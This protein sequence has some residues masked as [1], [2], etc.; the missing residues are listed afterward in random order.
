MK[1]LEQ[2]YQKFTLEHCIQQLTGTTDCINAYVECCQPYLGQ[3]KIALCYENQQ[4]ELQQWS[5]EQLDQASGY[6]ATYL[7]SLGLKAGDR[8]ATMLAKGAELLISMLAIWRIGA[9]YL[10]LFTEFET[11]AIEHRLETADT[12][13]I[14]IDEMYRERINRI[15]ISNI[16]T[17]HQQFNPK[18]IDA[19]FWTKIHQQN[20]LAPAVSRHLDDDFLMMFTS[21][22]V[23]LVKSLRVPLKALLSFKHYLVTAVDLKKEDRFF[24]MIDPAWAYGLYYGVIGALSLGHAVLWDREPFSV[25]RM[26]YLQHQHQI[27]NL[28]T[29]PTLL[30]QLYAQKTKLDLSKFSALAKVSSVGEPLNTDITYWLEQNL[31]IQTYDHYGQTETGIVLANHHGLDHLK[32]VGSVGYAVPG[33]RIVVLNHK[34]Q[35]VDQG[36][37]GML[38]IDTAHSPL[39]WFKSYGGNNRRCFQGQ[40]YLTGDM[41]RMNEISSI[42]FIARADDVILSSGYRVGPFDVESTLLECTEVQETAVIGKPDPERYE[43]IKAFIVLKQH[44][45]PSD[46][47]KERLQ[48]YVRTRLSK[49]I[50]LSEIEFVYS[51]PKTVT[52]KIQR[53]ILKQ[54]EMRRVQQAF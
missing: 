8:I 53:H 19:D 41:V 54:Q 44:L 42:E 28:M 39:F 40:Y 37:I 26:S 10:P 31:N 18:S 12:Q 51:L 13:L 3:N 5:Y 1:S 47:L 30:R 20:T 45:T 36:E 23:G 22:T 48:H 2:A 49:H 25:E 46:D 6:L 21:G 27:T 50:Y 17:V 7:Q 9:I 52:G 38:A 34:H 32:K 43:L 11:K 29:T 35:I 33:Y 16:L 24:N 15:E 14:I 4:G